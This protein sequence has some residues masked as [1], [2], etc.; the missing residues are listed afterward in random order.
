MSPDRIWQFVI[1]AILIL[2]FCWLMIS[3]THTAKAACTPP[4][5]YGPS[6]CYSDD[7][8]PRGDDYQYPPYPGD[9]P[10][11]PTQTKATPKPVQRPSGV[12]VPVITSPK[13][14]AAPVV[15][16]VE[17]TEDEKFVLMITDLLSTKW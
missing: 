1:G 9:A 5:G 7:D 6:W 11:A 4:P 16:V 12:V 15:V 10:A 3:C 8:P 2:V 17:P 13:P 14:E